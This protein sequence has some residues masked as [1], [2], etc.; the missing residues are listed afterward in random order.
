MEN[1]RLSALNKSLGKLVKYYRM[2]ADLNVD[3]LAWRADLDNNFVSQLERGKRNISLDTLFKLA[4][5]LDLRS[6]CDLLTEAKNDVYP[7]Y[8]RQQE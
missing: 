3:E 8:K 1:K 5:G 7:Q 2:K 4:S 6:P